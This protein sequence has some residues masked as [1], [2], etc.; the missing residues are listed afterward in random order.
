VQVRIIEAGNHAASL[1]IDDLRL[2]SALKILGVID[3]GYATVGN[4]HFLCLGVPWLEGG[5]ASVL[6]D[7]VGDGCFD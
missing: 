1:K 7:Q 5:N 6:K 3:S 2:R 4:D